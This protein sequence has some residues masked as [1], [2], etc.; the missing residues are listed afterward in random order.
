MNMRSNGDDLLTM[1][2]TGKVIYEIKEQILIDRGIIS[3]PVIHF[4]TIDKPD[5]L[6]GADYQDAYD[7][8][9]VNNEQLNSLVARLTVSLQS[10]YKILTLLE[11]Q[12]HFENLEHQ[13]DLLNFD[14]YK[15]LN[16][17]DKQ[18]TRTKTIDEFING[19]LSNICA[20]KI[21]DEGVTMPAIDVVIRAG[22]MKGDIKSKQQVGRGQGGKKDKPN[23]IHIIDFLVNT[24][25][26]L[27]E[28]SLAR[29]NMYKSLGYE[30]IIESDIIEKL[31]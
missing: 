20:S 27:V 1:A 2:A 9:I 5:D 12:E 8:G 14:N 19:D 24:N 28:H 11:R 7:K 16:G 15:I 18:K 22:C 31:N 6:E 4:Y 25:Q 13:F 23:E 3:R 17:K 29:F 26:Y 30:I 10:N 21:L